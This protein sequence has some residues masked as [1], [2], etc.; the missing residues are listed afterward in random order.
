MIF[1]KIVAIKDIFAIENL[2][3]CR[4]KVESYLLREARLIVL[5]QQLV[6]KS[7]FQNKFDRDKLSIKEIDKAE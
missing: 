7:D 3:A 1:S 2:V 4:E 6:N 5:L